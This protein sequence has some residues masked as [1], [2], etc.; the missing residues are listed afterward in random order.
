MFCNLQ[1]VHHALKPG[2]A[3]EFW[4]DICQRYLGQ[5]G[6]LHNT[7]RQRVSSAHSHVRTLPD[8]HGVGDFAVADPLSKYAQELHGTPP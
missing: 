3:R 8:A 6:H 4:R 7:W 5:A 1:Q 2:A